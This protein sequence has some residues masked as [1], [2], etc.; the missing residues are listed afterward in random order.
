MNLP[1]VY[2]RISAERKTE[3]LS[4]RALGLGRS[5]SWR[6]L[7]GRSEILPQTAHKPKHPEVLEERPSDKKTIA[8]RT[9]ECVQCC[10]AKTT[11]KHRLTERPAE[12]HTL[13]QRFG[14]A[15]DRT[16]ARMQLESPLNALFPTSPE[17][18]ADR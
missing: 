10:L 15:P 14:T 3:A 8:L 6:H 17:I 12:T 4:G 1:K 13:A 9:R 5:R 18:H 7:R 2:A 16:E 11:R